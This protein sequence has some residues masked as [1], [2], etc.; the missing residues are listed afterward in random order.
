M[1]V[2]VLRVSSA[3]I[4]KFSRDSGRNGINQELGQLGFC[5]PRESIWNRRIDGLYKSFYYFLLRFRVS[6]LVCQ[7]QVCIYIY[8]Y[9]KI[10]S[11][12]RGLVQS[13]YLT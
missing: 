5:T 13:L 10:V 4:A 12:M 2:P 9:A 8:I 7:G 6:P 3:K 11:T 1:R